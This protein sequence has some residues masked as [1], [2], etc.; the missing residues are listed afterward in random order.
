MKKILKSNIT[1]YILSFIIP[2]LFVCLG[3][4][5]QDIYPGGNNYILTYDLRAQLFALYGYLSNRGP[6]FDSLLYSMSG[7]LGGGFYGTL[8]LYISPFDLIY[9]FIPLELIPQAVYWMI[10]IKIGL[11]GLCMSIYLSKNKK[12]SLSGL[13]AV[14]LSCCYALMSYN[15]MYSMSPMWYDAVMLLPLV[16]LFLDRVILGKKSP[17]FILFMAFCFI[18]DYY[19][20]YMVVIALILYFAFRIIEEGYTVQKV[21]THTLSF[22]LHGIM[23]A[24]L[25]L[26]VLIPV[27]LDFG[28]G[29]MA[30]GSVVSGDLIKN[31]LLDVIL[32]FRSQSYSGLDFNASPNIFCGSVVLVLAL[33]WLIM[34]K[35]DIK[36]RIAAFIIIAFYILSFI[37]GPLDR[38]WHGFKEPVCF[39]CRYSFTFCFFMIIIAARGIS[40]LKQSALIKSKSLMALISFAAVFYTFFELYVN[41]A[42]IF[43]RIATESGYT[44]KEEFDRYLEVNELLVPDEMLADAD[45]YGR[46]ISNIKFSSYDGALFGYDGIPRFSSSYNFRVS[47]FLRKMGVASIYHTVRTT[48]ITPPVSSLINGRYFVSYFID[49]S[50]YYNTLSDYGMYW[51]YE[52]NN[53]LPLA[54]LTDNDPM[55]SEGEFSDDVF[56]NINMV[57]RELSGNNDL[58]IF[59]REEVKETAVDPDFK[60]E[61]NTAGCYEFTTHHSGHYFYYVSYIADDYT[62]ED[63]TDNGYF[64]EYI[65]VRKGYLDG[66]PL[67]EFG[68]NQYHYC[69]DLGF[70]DE[71]EDHVLTI[72]SSGK[73][74]GEV[75]LYYFDNDANERAVSSFVGYDLK[76][77]GSK[78]IVLEGDSDTSGNLFI[79]LPFE[80]GYRVYIDGNK[81]DYESY[82]DTFLLIPVG[83]GSHEVVIKYFPPGLTMGIILSL[84]FVMGFAGV[85]LNDKQKR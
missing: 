16:A 74:I 64:R 18:S 48:G 49:Q 17:A 78:R 27:V 42:Y 30:E 32:S 36:A 29:K 52:N 33:A 76:E 6:G 34:G 71:G 83:S 2:V 69:E 22:G 44:L 21:F 12:A 19:M 39:S 4:Y 61:G 66:N 43:A 72:D 47:D 14:A 82:R 85:C 55:S 8:C 79:S 60:P 38:A 68:N 58:N 45:T 81:A 53:V 77:I 50:D 54:F 57:Y 40:A 25:S 3:L 73:E 28:R 11:C 20:A 59:I 35:K 24:G 75:Y 80:A 84:C 1:I 65:V 31:S 23:A 10:V 41:G 56:E 37:L 70:M 51:L 15:I 5:A 13:W 62:E 7:A 26:F 63:E 46:V 67:G 9:S